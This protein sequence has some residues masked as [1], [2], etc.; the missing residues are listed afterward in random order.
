MI[1]R[2][3]PRSRLFIDPGF[4]VL[5][6]QRRRDPDVVDSQSQIATKAACAIVPPGVMAPFFS[7]QAKCVGKA[8]LLDLLQG[9]PFGFAKKNSVL[10]QKRIVDVALFRSDIKIT[11][12]QN[13]RLWIV[14][15]IQ[16]FAKM[17]HPA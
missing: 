2:A 17:S 16:K 14:L 8:P 9:S 3:L 12:Q 7:V 15:L 13:P 11:T 6:R 5:L 1:R 4:S 10:P